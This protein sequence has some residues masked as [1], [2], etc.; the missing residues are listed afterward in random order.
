MRKIGLALPAVEESTAWGVRHIP[1]MRRSPQTPLGPNRKFT[2]YG[3]R[4]L[5]LLT[6]APHFCLKCMTGHGCEDEPCTVAYESI[7]NSCIGIPTG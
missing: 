7:C 2:I 1:I 4:Q 6:E 3:Y 5:P